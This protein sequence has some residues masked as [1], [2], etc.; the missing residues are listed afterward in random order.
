[1]HDH[2]R[3]AIDRIVRAQGAVPDL[4]EKASRLPL[5]QY[6]GNLRVHHSFLT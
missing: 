5:G 6:Q 2:A 1:M 3:Q 4:F